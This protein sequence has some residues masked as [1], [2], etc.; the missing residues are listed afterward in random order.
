MVVVDLATEKRRRHPNPSPDTRPTGSYHLSEYRRRGAYP[1]RWA[2]IYAQAGRSIPALG[3]THGDYFYGDIPCTRNLLPEEIKGPPGHYELETG[4]VIAE[5]FRDRDPDSIPAA[6][7][8]SH[9]PFTWG[10][11]A[12]DAAHNAVRA[13][14]ACLHA[15][16]ISC[17]SVDIADETWSCWI[18]TTCGSTVPALLR[19][20]NKSEIAFYFFLRK[21]K[22]HPV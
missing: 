2:T 19:T 1:R 11:D 5:T 12:R 21:R 9:G 6:L 18:S 10:K 16:Q 4:K 20:E 17:R 13:G 14:R 7:V 8:R 3:T 15:W 22:R